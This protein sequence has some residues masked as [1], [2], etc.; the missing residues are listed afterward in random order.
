[1]S[2]AKRRKIR[3]IRALAASTT[4]PEEAKSARAKADAMEKTLGPSDSTTFRR[5]Q[6]FPG[7]RSD[8]VWTD[9]LSKI[10]P[11]MMKAFQEALQRHMDSVIFGTSIFRDGERIDP[12]DFYT[13]PKDQPW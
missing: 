8:G 13:S 6:P 10:S 9:E 7:V 1:M 2:E 4:F 5:A 11:E 3:Q 12:A